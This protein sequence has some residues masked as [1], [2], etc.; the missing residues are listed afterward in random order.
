MYGIGRHSAFRRCP[1]DKERQGETAAVDIHGKRS[2]GLR[3]GLVLLFPAPEI[4]R[5]GN[6][7]EMGG[8]Q[9]RLPGA[10]QRTEVQCQAHHADPCY[11]RGDT[12]AE[13]EEGGGR[14][15][16]DRGT[17]QGRTSKGS[18]PER[19]LDLRFLQGRVQPDAGPY[20][21][22]SALLHEEEWRQAGIPSERAEPTERTPLCGHRLYPQ[23]G[24]RL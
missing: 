2:L 16:T 24:S 22:R 10:F 4:L 17:V 7:L 19:G 12:A 13:S 21:G 20:H 18:R 6:V 9:I 3:S 15:E 8:T 5:C 14:T 23:D 11:L 1:A